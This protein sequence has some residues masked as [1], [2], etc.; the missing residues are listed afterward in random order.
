VGTIFYADDK[1][2]VIKRFAFALQ[3]DLHHASHVPVVMRQDNLEL[4]KS[5]TEF[6]IREFLSSRFKLDIRS[7]APFRMAP[8]WTQRYRALLK[9]N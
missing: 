7:A 6:R 9:A 8:A 1:V 2:E 5:G 4:R 3:F